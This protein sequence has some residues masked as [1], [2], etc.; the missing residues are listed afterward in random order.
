MVDSTGSINNLPDGVLTEIL[1]RVPTQKCALTCKLVCKQWY[2]LISCSNF[3]SCFIT[4]HINPREEEEEYQKYSLISQAKRRTGGGRCISFLGSSNQDLESAWTQSKSTYFGQESE[5]IK[6]LASNKDLLLCQLTI[7][8]TV[9]RSHKAW[10][11][12][13]PFTVQ[14]IELPPPPIAARAMAITC[15]E[16]YAK[17]IHG[18]YRRPDH[19]GRR[20]KVWELQEGCSSGGVNGEEE[21]LW[22]LKYS[23]N[24]WGPYGGLLQFDPVNEDI[25]YLLRLHPSRCSNIV[26][27]NL[28]TGNLAVVSQLSPDLLTVNFYCKCFL[29]AHP[30][31]P[32]PL[33]S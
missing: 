14:W 7:K 1:S 6:I 33:P 11:I 18:R 16:P 28:G 29:L 9:V 3:V 30:L 4:N 20:F 10:F 21:W 26:S 32:V 31:W 8:E 2:S 25:V 12:Y 5:K 19:Q 22:S 27:F 23:I 13:N 15:E 24:A 17:D